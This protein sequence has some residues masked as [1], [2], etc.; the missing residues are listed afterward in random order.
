MFKGLRLY[1][2]II[3]RSDQLSVPFAIA[4]NQC[5]FTAD[6]LASCFGD[7]SRSKPNVLLDVLDR[8]RIDKIAAFLGCSGFR[9]LQM[10]DVF[11]WPDYCLIQSSSVF[12]SSS[13]AQDSREAADYF[14]SVT[15]SNVSGSAE[16]IIDELIAATWSRDLR[17]A[18]EKT[19]IP[20]L[21]LRSWRVGKPKPTLKDLEAIRVLAK[22]L[23]MGT[24][25][26]MM[27]LGVLT[28]N[29]FMN[30][31][32]TIDIESELNHA[33]DVEIL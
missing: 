25:L 10:A 33:L 26:V 1:Q 27:A 6:S 3:D 12:K 11:S 29:D 30:D 24:P 17:D 14:D 18:A 31:G 9:V 16:F 19:K 22:H 32:V 15:K 28:P 8:K 7:V 21:K 13:D 23:D 2:A 4:S 20:F 5:G